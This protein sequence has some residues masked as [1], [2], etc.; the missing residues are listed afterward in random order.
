MLETDKSKVA[1]SSTSM[2]VFTVNSLKMLRALKKTKFYKSPNLRPIIVVKIPLSKSSK[3]FFFKSV[4]PPLALDA[5]KPYKRTQPV[6]CACASRTTYH[7]RD[8]L[9][10]T[11]GTLPLPFACWPVGPHHVAYAPAFDPQKRMLR[12][13]RLLP[14]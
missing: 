5:S 2:M 9:S 7:D 4:S 12:A 8:L 6:P 11:Q 1:E 3:R 14:I 10:T 13:P